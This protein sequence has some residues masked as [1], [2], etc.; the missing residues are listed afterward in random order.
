MSESTAAL[1]GCLTSSLN[2]FACSSQ[3]GRDSIKS[4]TCRER[5][6]QRER[7]RRAYQ[8]ETVVCNQTPLLLSQPHYSL[9]Q[10]VTIITTLVS[11]W[12]VLPT[13]WTLQCWT[14]SEW[15][16]ATPGSSLRCCSQ[17]SDRS[18]PGCADMADRKTDWWRAA[19]RL[20]SGTAGET[21]GSEA[22]VTT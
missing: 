9:S 15:T 2:C 16:P 20:D 19:C 22:G 7:E 3:P 6:R 11:V 17:Q 14:V 18:R 21:D 4:D 1:P 8:R 13:C 10:T 5:D 12:L